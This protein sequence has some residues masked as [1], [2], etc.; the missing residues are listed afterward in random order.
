MRT[1]MEEVETENERLSDENK[2]LQLRSAKRLSLSGTETSYIDR[3]VC[4]CVVD[5]K[6]GRKDGWEMKEKL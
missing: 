1:R 4:G 3:Q 2:R 5:Q 6:E